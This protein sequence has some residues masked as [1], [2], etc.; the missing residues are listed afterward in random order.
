MTRVVV[1]MSGGVDSSLAAALLKQRGFEVIG[2]TLRLWRYQEPSREWEGFGSCCSPAA[3]EDARSVAYQ[4]QVPFYI[5]NVEAEFS[6][7]IIS[8]FV[9][10]YLQGRTPNPCLFCNRQ[11]KFGS[12]LRRARGWGADYVA[13]GH[14]A[15]IHYDPAKGRYLLWRSPDPR[16]DQSYF[17]FNLTQ[18]QLAHLLLPLAELCKEETRRMATELGLAV[19]GK[20]ESQ[21]ICF[22][23]EGD[24][25]EFLREVAPDEIRPGKIR[26][27]NGRI[28]GEHAGI[29]F[30]TIG[31]RK[32]LG[33][34]AA[35][36]L[37]VVGL[38]PERNE[39]IIGEEQDLF[40]SQLVVEGV[41]FIPFDELRG[42]MEVSVKIRYQHPGARAHI[43]PLP[44]GRV[45]VDFEEPQ[46]AITPGQAAVFYQEDLVV[47]GG[48][49]SSDPGD[50]ARHRA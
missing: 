46:K 34:T 9:R 17:L 19:A 26:D 21:E 37:F 47:G 5:L 40:R 20:P 22:L 41:H 48:I 3:I 50:L 10:E 7:T 4:L 43:R 6:R 11:L 45:E 18:D 25:R 49:I 28:L 24:Y 42:E 32:G 39:V 16:K 38:D 2:I 36:P 12:L 35:R 29:P 30:Y 1:A 27:R 8:Y 33:I 15:R 31:Q 13:S 14:Y 44:A 23:P